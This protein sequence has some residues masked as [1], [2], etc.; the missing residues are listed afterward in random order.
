[1]TVCELR[2]YRL[3]ERLKNYLN[4]EKNIYWNIIHIYTKKDYTMATIYEVNSKFDA[5]IKV[6]RVNSK[7]DA[8][9]LVYR[10]NSRFDAKGDSLWF[11]VNSKFDASAKIFW[12]N[13]KFDADVCIYFVNSKFDA[14]WNK[15]GHKFV[16]KFGK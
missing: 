11:L 13:S 8:D 5:D 4:I 15:S 3:D 10:V 2:L 7:F 6:F 12:V 9:L 14:K 16:G 1:M